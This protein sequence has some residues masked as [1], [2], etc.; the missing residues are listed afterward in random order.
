MKKWIYIL[1]IGLALI[2][3]SCIDDKT[4]VDEI[5]ATPNLIGFSA[6]TTSFAGIADGT[7]YGNV[8]PVEIFGPT[9]E[10]LSGS[11]TATVT[12]DPSSTAI[13]GTHFRLESNTIQVSSD[14]NFANVFPVVMLTDGIETPLAVNPK[15]VLKLTTASG[16]GNI[17]ASGA[18]LT[19]TLLYLCPSFLAEETYV[20]SGTYDHPSGYHEDFNHGT[21]SLTELGPGEF[22]T[23][24]TGHWGPGGTGGYLSPPAAR[25]GFIFKDVCGVISIEQQNLGNYY[26]NIVEGSGT[27]DPDTGDIHLEYT[28]C[29]GGACREYKVDYTKK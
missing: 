12:V 4:I 5:K 24:S 10:T 8:L 22:L 20:V 7:E 19:I 1:S 3:P 16:S 29:A 13:E 17:T 11:Y 25:N 26:S 27:V 2:L 9:T 28:V 15:V 6:R 23:M 18:T 21:E 14:G